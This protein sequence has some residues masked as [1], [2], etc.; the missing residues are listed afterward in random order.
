MSVKLLNNATQRN[1]VGTPIGNPP[2]GSVLDY[3]KSDNNLYI[4]NSNGK[5]FRV[6]GNG[7]KLFLS[8]TLV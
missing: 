1:K 4:K 8:Q 3:P 2:I 6:E 5:E 7:S